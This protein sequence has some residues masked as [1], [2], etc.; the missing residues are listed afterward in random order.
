MKNNEDYKTVMKGAKKTILFTIAK[1]HQNKL[2][3]RRTRRFTYKKDVGCVVVTPNKT[4]KIT[5]W[6][7]HLQLKNRNLITELKARIKSRQL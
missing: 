5:Q 4:L 3:F 7:F 2:R 1:T 6:K